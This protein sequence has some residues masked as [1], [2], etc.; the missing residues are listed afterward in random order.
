M[1]RVESRKLKVEGRSSISPEFDGG[2]WR[3][4]KRKGEAEE[5]LKERAEEEIS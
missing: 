5:E 2:I 4:C 3:G 1:E